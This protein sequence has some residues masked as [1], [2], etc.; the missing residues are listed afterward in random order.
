MVWSLVQGVG[1]TNVLLYNGSV[2]MEDGQFYNGHDGFQSKIQ[3]LY[4]WNVGEWSTRLVT[5]FLFILVYGS[6]LHNIVPGCGLWSLTSEVGHWVL[7]GQWSH[8]MV[9]GSK[10]YSIREDTK[11]HLGQFARQSIVVSF[12]ASTIHGIDLVQCMAWHWP[13]SEAYNEIGTCKKLSS[14][15]VHP[16]QWTMSKS[17]PHRTLIWAVCNSVKIK[18]GDNGP[19]H[20]RIWWPNNVYI[21][22]DGC[23]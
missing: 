7:R 5:F 17:R 15:S 1:I 6:T 23:Q 18:A 8:R 3:A 12:R 4:L 10:R 9:I 2:V 11:I 19:S 16:V 21:V 13:L 20:N 14:C 22:S